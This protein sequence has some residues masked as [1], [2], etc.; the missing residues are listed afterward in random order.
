MSLGLDDGLLMPSL[1]LWPD[2][3]IVTGRNR[4]LNR[5]TAALPNEIKAVDFVRK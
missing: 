3:A 4:H 1:W 5:E 2:E